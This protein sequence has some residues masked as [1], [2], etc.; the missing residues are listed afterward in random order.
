VKAASCCFRLPEDAWRKAEAAVRG[1]DVL[2]AIGTSGL[3]YPAASLPE[4]AKRCGKA[5]IQI[6]PTP[7]GHDAVATCV[8]RGT[9]GTVL[10][11]LVVAAYSE[12]TP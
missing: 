8:L 10:P 4:I 9:A 12:V 7:G 1:C 2:V 3:V 5:V 11:A 6:N